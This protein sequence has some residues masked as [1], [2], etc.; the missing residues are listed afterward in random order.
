MR[1]RRQ[2]PEP[3]PQRAATSGGPAPEVVYEH[4]PEHAWR[5]LG[6]ID[7]RNPFA[8]PPDYSEARNW[9]PWR[10]F[11]RERGLW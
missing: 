7:P 6:E 10:E 4:V 1:P 11:L 5:R 9:K 8:E 3:P 2:K